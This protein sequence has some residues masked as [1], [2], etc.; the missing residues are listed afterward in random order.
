M[1]V[2]RRPG[3]SRKV[4]TSARPARLAAGRRLLARGL[5]G[6][7]WPGES[8]DRLLAEAEPAAF[9]AGRTIYRE[10]TPARRFFWVVDGVARVSLR[11]SLGHRVPLS[12]AR[13]GAL[14]G[15]SLVASGRRLDSAVAFTQVRA[16][17][18]EAERFDEIL[19]GLPPEASRRTEHGAQ[20]DHSRTL[21]RTVRLLTH[22]DLGRLALALLDAAEGLS[23]ARPVARGT[24][25][26]RPARTVRDARVRIG[27]AALADIAGIAPAGVP[28]ALEQL[29]AR[30]LVRRRGRDLFLRVRELLEL[31]GE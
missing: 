27:P 23:P 19:R 14:L 2:P 30:G 8:I 22:D 1:S 17:S 26:A 25:A 29:V 5:E 28:R 24:R 3:G 15:R 9:A 7:G 13:P 12:L 20:A 21:V 11:G 6:L 16:L 10:G 31:C 18:I 4:P